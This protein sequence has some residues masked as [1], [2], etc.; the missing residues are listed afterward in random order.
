MPRKPQAWLGA[1]VAARDRWASLHLAVARAGY[2]GCAPA[3]A[4]RSGGPI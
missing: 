3:P 4:L 1:V 2:D